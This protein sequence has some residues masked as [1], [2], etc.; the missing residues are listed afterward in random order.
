M[1]QSVHSVLD[2]IEEEDSSVEKNSEGM[3]AYTA[4][5]SYLDKAKLDEGYEPK[6]RRRDSQPRYS[7]LS[8]KRSIEEIFDRDSRGMKKSRSS[9][10]QPKQHFIKNKKFGGNYPPGKFWSFFTESLK[11]LPLWFPNVRNSLLEIISYWKIVLSK[12]RAKNV[13]ARAKVPEPRKVLQDRW[14]RRGLPNSALLSL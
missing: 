1:S 12:C 10:G 4:N 5:P 2:W 11:Y 9:K 7:I 3:S 13:P 8:K 14:P 6:T